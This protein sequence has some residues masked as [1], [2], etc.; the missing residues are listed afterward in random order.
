MISAHD[1]LNHAKDIYN[2]FDVDGSVHDNIEME[3]RS[4]ARVAYYALYHLLRDISDTLP[5]EGIGFGSHE[6]IENKLCMSKNQDYIYLATQMN[7]SKKGRVRA[8]YHL[9]AEFGK[10]EANRI[11]N[12]VERVFARVEKMNENS[13]KQES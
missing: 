12:K 3:Y 5:G 4:C 11:L 2:R 13:N 7:S 1:F 10:N 6:K 9:D 8:D